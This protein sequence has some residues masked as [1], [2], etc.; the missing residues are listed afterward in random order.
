MRD[1][2]FHV[3]MLFKGPVWPQLSLY[4]TRCFKQRAQNFFAHLTQCWAN[5]V[6]LLRLYHK[7]LSVDQSTTNSLSFE[8]PLG[9]STWLPFLTAEFALPISW[10]FLTILPSFKLSEIQVP[11]YCPGLICLERWV[12][13]EGMIAWGL[14]S[15]HSFRKYSFQ[16][17]RIETMIFQG[18]WKVWQVL[19]WCL[20]SNPWNLCIC[21][22]WDFAAVIK[23][24]EMGRW[25]CITWMGP[26]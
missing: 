16:F 18:Y 14:W 9:F 7:C 13:K 23:D 3:G 12:V 20:Y 19:Q 2:A 17:S 25:S 10:G 6:T 4:Y 11:R 8:K 24:L 22:L 21:Y 15:T 26:M 1:W 5:V